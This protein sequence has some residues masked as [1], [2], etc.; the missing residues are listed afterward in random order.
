MSEGR[1]R[2]RDGRLRD[3]RSWSAAPNGRSSG[4]IERLAWL[5]GVLGVALAADRCQL[6]PVGPLP[7]A[8]P[9][10]TLTLRGGAHLRVAWR[11]S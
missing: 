1:R 5:E 11:F 7:V 10:A 9:A 3:P 2:Q 4:F 8:Q 6:S